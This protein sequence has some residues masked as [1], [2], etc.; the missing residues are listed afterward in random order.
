MARRPLGRITSGKKCT[1]PV[2]SSWFKDWKKSVLLVWRG[3]FCCSC[4]AWK[5]IATARKNYSLGEWKGLS[6]DLLAQVFFLIFSCHW[7]IQPVKNPLLPAAHGRW[8]EGTT[9]TETSGY[10]ISDIWRRSFHC[11]TQTNKTFWAQTRCVYF[12][13]FRLQLTQNNPSCY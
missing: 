13:L 8:L 2:K 6:M 4:N 5:Q 7:G 11:P 9:A 1:N 12:Y 3:P 10:K